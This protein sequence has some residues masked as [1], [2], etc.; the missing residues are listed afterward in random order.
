MRW[1][2]CVRRAATTGWT[3]PR[4][5]AASRAASSRRPLQGRRPREAQQ[6]L[7][8]LFASCLVFVSCLV[9]LYPS[10]RP[11]LQRWSPRGVEEQLGRWC[12]PAVRLQMG[13]GECCTDMSDDPSFAHHLWPSNKICFL[14]G[15][16]MHR[17]GPWAT[18]PCSTTTR[19]PA[20]GSR[21]PPW[22][23]HYSPTTHPSVGAAAL[24]SATMP[25]P[26]AAA[27]VRLSRQLVLLNVEA[28]LMWDSKSMIQSCSRCRQTEACG[29]PHHQLLNAITGSERVWDLTRGRAAS[30]PFV[31]PPFISAASPGL[32][33]PYGVYLRKRKD[34]ASS[35]R[36]RL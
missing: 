20:T 21:Q 27:L 28:L 9:C 19:R 34:Y 6:Q 13:R 33:G 11:A 5:S 36:Y 1:A 7:G 23:A 8:A 10:P 25:Q 12:A 18:W 22:W 2:R 24:T 14:S 17:L 26:P 32:R 4:S 16:L 15:W 3:C 31:S 30:P 29:G 35:D